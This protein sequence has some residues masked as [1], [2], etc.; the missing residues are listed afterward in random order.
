MRNKDKILPFQTPV[1][2]AVY[3][4]RISMLFQILPRL[5]CKR[6]TVKPW[7]ASNCPASILQD[8]QTF[9]INFNLINELCLAIRVVC[10]TED[11]MIT[12][13]LKILTPP[14]SG[15]RGDHLPRSDAQSQVTVFLR[16]CDFSEQ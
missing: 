9:L 4:A 13:E 8:E 15:I 16:N 11:H 2:C 7:I 6:D 1:H 10:D 5:F 12:G 3:W 14:P